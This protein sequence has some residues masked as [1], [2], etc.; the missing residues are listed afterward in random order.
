MTV[1]GLDPPRDRE[2][3]GAGFIGAGVAAGGVAD[4]GEV[5]GADAPWWVD[6]EFGQ[7]RVPG[8][9]DLG[10]LRRSP[11]RTAGAGAEWMRRGSRRS[12]GQVFTRLVS[13]TRISRGQP[14]QQHLGAGAVLAAVVDRV[15]PASA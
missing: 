2:G 3:H 12:T 5:S 15:S 11:P 8:A 13:M 9:A 6:V 4:G 14:A 10:A 7:D 1:G